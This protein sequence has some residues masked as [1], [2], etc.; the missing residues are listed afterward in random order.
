MTNDVDIISTHT[1]TRRVRNAN[2]FVNRIY[3]QI[4]LDGFQW[5]SLA[6][7]AATKA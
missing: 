5:N 2:K 3:K 7:A 1:Y 6:V 4:D